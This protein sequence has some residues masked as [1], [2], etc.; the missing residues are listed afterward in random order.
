MDGKIEFSVKHP[1][2]I[3]FYKDFSW[4]NSNAIGGDWAREFI[5]EVSHWDASIQH[6]GRIKFDTTNAEVAQSVRDVAIAAGYGATLSHR[7]DD[8]KPPFS[9]VHTVHILKNNM[10]GARG[11]WNLEKDFAGYVYCVTVPS[12]R[13]L[14]RRN[15]CTLVSGNSGNPVWHYCWHPRLA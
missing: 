3:V 9:D 2:S 1:E 5:E 6:E 13:V 15:R 4:V 14:V 11:T 8:R 10:L 12:G 7:V